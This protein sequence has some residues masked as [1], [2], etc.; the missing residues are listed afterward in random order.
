MFTIQDF[1]RA[2]IAKYGI[3][4]TVLFSLQRNEFAYAMSCANSTDRGDFTEYLVCDLLK[5]NGYSV[6]RLGGSVNDYD[7]LLNESI[8]VEVK[9]ATL[10]KK[11]NQYV[12]Q[13][14][15]PELFDV[16]FMLFL[17]PDG[18]VAKWST[19]ED[20]NEWAITHKRGKEGY[21]ITFND[22]IENDNFRYNDL[23]SFMYYYHPRYTRYLTV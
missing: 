5:S 13:K 10:R 1:E 17:T 7:L 14:V 4:D 2:K 9:T 18:M 15:K 8:R 22:Y 12:C 20:V 21:N 11:R 3:E 16:L 23:E 19:T 6:R